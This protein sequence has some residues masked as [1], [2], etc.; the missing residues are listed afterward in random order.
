M[1]WTC[2]WGHKAHRLQRS[3]HWWE[4]SVHIWWAEFTHF[5][6]FLLIATCKA[7]AIYWLPI[8][9]IIVGHKH[10]SWGAVLHPVYP[11]WYKTND[12]KIPLHFF[13]YRCVS[14]SFQ[15]LQF[16][17]VFASLYSHLRSFTCTCFTVEQ[18][19]VFFNHF[20]Y[21]LYRTNYHQ[22]ALIM[23]SHQIYLL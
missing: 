17:I 1:G 18:S 3:D 15:R 5:S 4:V 22:N 13:Q 8:F 16:F 20:P 7:Y 19:R 6:N 23:H 12:L 21:Q 14:P 2:F 9:F 10:C 11:L